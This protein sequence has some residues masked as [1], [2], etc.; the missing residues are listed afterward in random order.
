MNRRSDDVAASMLASLPEAQRVR[1]VSAMAEVH[2]LLGAAGARIAR[3]DPAAPDARWCVAQY[4]AEI[5]ARFDQGFDPARSI[6]A[7]DTELRPPTGAFLVAT[8]DGA[9][10]GCGAVKTLAPGVGSLKRMWVAG[11]MRGLGFGARLLGALEDEARALGLRTLRLETNR[12]L[13]EAIRLY[14]R[15]GY[16]E[17]AP[18]NDEPYAHHWF[19]KRLD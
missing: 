19:E 14:R 8:A 5:A 7:N 4:F 11:A 18:F 16:V 10:V 12:A 15:A 6:P 13:V 3:V 1:L 9:P 2:R 17:V